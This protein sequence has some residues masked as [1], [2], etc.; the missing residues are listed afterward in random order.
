[1][2]PPQ[3]LNS[4]A[5]TAC[6]LSFLNISDS[7]LS[8]LHVFLCWRRLPTK[9][10]RLIYCHSK[11]ENEFWSALLEKAYAKCD[12]LSKPTRTSSS[13]SP[14]NRLLTRCSTSRRLYR[15]YESLRDGTVAD[16][17]TDLTGGIPKRYHLRQMLIY[18]NPDTRQQA[19]NAIASA[20]SA[21]A[22]VTAT[23]KV[24]CHFSSLLPKQFH[25]N[26]PYFLE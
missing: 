17:L 4:P 5:A 8:L 10:G 9:R 1:M 11:D 18:K 25:L 7:N 15:D 19:F 24:C 23:I 12:S 13:H 20:L 6:T 14:S 22:F 2:V 16:C 3:I 21:K 26:I